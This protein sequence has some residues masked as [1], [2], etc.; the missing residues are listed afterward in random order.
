M[1]EIYKTITSEPEYE[2]SNYGNVRRKD[3]GHIK[4]TRLDGGGY[5]RVTLYPSGKTYHIHRLLGL[6]FIP[7]P[8]MKPEINH[9]DNVRNNNILTNLEWATKSENAKH[10]IICGTVLDICGSKNPSAK[11]TEKEAYAIKYE[12]ED[13]TNRQC[14]DIYGIQTN[15]VR[16]I[17]KN[18]M[19]KHI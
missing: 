14:A 11:L 4:S 1:T 3:S 18:E 5:E 17:R 15:S 16:R 6:E 8:M 7:N 19:W 10:R 9:K 13:L 12:H 2:I